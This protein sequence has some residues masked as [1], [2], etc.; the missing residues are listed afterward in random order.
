MTTSQRQM[1]ARAIA[2]DEAWISRRRPL[3][4]PDEDCSDIEE[5]IAQVQRDVDRMRELLSQ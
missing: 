5:S 4:E 1:I 2:T 3:I